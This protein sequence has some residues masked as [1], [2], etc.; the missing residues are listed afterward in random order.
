MKI[1]LSGHFVVSVVNS[2]TLASGRVKKNELQVK[3][4]Y[5]IAMIGA[6]NQIN[7]AL[8]R[9]SAKLS[10]KYII[11][12]F[13]LNIDISYYVDHFCASVTQQ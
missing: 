3:V 5:L 1:A 6:S 7:N 12:Y 4:I 9:D 10:G 13:P 11:V 2:L 8:S